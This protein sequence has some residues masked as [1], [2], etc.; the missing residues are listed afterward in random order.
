MNDEKKKPLILISND[1]GYH[2]GGLRYLCEFLSDMAD[3]LVVAPEAARSGFA[4]AFSAT[5]PLY[6]KRRKDIAGA[7][8]WSCTGTPVDCVKVALDQLMADRW[9]DLII[10]GINHGDNSTVNTH[11]SGTMGVAMEGCLKYIPSIAFSSCDYNPDANLSYLRRYVRKIVARVLEE[12]LPKGVCLN[13]NFPKVTN[14]SGLKVC[15]MGY[16]SWINEVVKERHPHGYDYYWMTGK[17]RNDEPDATDNDRW[18]LANGYVCVTPTQMD[19]TSYKT[20]E[21]MKG[22]EE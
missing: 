18:A 12:G 20:L 1:D 14:F 5:T 11:Y 17:Y 7:E 15:R 22:W 4:C 19:V 21:Q 9:P 8:V 3:I 10:G 16:G 13:V 6:L 2:S